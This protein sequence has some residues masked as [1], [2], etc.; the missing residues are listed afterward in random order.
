LGD[1][2]GSSAL[3]DP[4]DHDSSPPSKWSQNARYQRIHAGASNLGCSPFKQTRSEGERYVSGTAQWDF[5]G[6]RVELEHVHELAKTSA[7]LKLVWSSPES[8]I[9][10]SARPRISVS[11]GDELG[12][13]LTG[14]RTFDRVF[15]I[16]GP[17]RPEVAL[18]AL[19]AEARAALLAL[20]GNLVH[21]VWAEG[22]M[23]AF[24]LERNPC[25]LK[26]LDGIDDLIGRCAVVAKT[27]TRDRKPLLDGLLHNARH[28]PNP[29]IRARNRRML[30]LQHTESAQAEAIA[31][32][33]LES[34]DVV[35]RAVAGIVLGSVQSIIPAL[36]QIRSGDLEA[37]PV[38]VRAYGLAVN[39]S[40]EEGP[41]SGRSNAD[42]LAMDGTMA[43]AVATV[44]AVIESGHGWSGAWLAERFER[45]PELINSALAHL[46]LADMADLEALLLAALAAQRASGRQVNPNVLVEVIEK[47]GQ[48]GT[49]KSVPELRTHCDE[50]FDPTYGK[51]PA[52]AAIAAIQ[53]R[54]KGGEVG[55]LAVVT[56]DDIR[57]GLS[58]ADEDA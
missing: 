12:A 18:A 13:R 52:R 51:K 26:D 31:A 1:L 36:T 4:D 47:L 50:F 41:E 40:D 35:E 58:D 27:L 29:Q 15:V 23:A 38:L 20:E 5:D 3:P 43:A 57:G 6:H 9:G 54:V 19:S 7:M 25:L 37:H 55:Q 44:Q 56:D 33:G 42:T 11:F 39:V 46:L 16:D 28:D 49:V 2:L 24:R 22:A 45:R 21:Q 30:L 34:D 8:E 53:A 17:G 32:S 14:D 10:A 48:I